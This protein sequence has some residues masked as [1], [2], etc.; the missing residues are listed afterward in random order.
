MNN[1]ELKDPYNDIKY[2]SQNGHKDTV[3]LLLKDPRVDPAS[4]DNE[5]IKLALING[6]KEIVKLLLKYPR[7]DFSFDIYYLDERIKE[8]LLSNAHIRKNYDVSERLLILKNKII[9]LLEIFNQDILYNI[10]SYHYL[11][12][13]NL[14]MFIST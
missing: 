13:D 3:E 11:P 6:H 12:V 14:Y 5:A 7:F 10:Y 4:I 1:L 9:L 2:A 8:I